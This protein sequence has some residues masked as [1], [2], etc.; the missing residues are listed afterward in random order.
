MDLCPDREPELQQWTAPP[1]VVS[2]EH[3]SVASG[4]AVG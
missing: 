4:A 1:S 3:P 2:V